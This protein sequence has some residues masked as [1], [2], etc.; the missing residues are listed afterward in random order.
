MACKWKNGKDVNGLAA[1]KLKDGDVKGS[2]GYAAF[3]KEHQEGNL[4]GFKKTC[5][6]VIAESKKKCRDG[7]ATRWNAVAT[8]RDS[9]DEKCES[10]YAN[11]D[12]SCQSKVDNL[13]KVFAQKRAK[14]GEQKTCYEGHCKEFPMVWMKTEEKEQKDEVKSQCEK[15]CTEKNIKIACETKWAADIDFVRVKI[16]SDCAEKSGVSECFKGKKDSVSADY[17]KCKSEAKGVCDKAYTECTKKGNADKNFKDA[18]AFCDDRKN[19]CAKQA[20]ENC[21]NENRSNLN[22]AEAECNKKAGKELTKCR[23]DGLD[24]LKKDSEKKC[25]DKRKPTCKKDCNGSCEVGKMKECLL[26]LESKDDP[27]K[28]FCEDFW[29]LL[30]NAAE[31]DPVTGD[32]ITLLSL[33]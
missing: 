4:E 11:F 17:D 19:V 30:H 28:M 20:D 16:D 27:G 24:K 8:K 9:C 25:I 26:K 2:D 18:K 23:D 29:T 10:V 14:A 33:P 32:P 5:G 31:A 21:E 15:R 13:D 1:E 3:V 12:R 7:C 22:K 6:L